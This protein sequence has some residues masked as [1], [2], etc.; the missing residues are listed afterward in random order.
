[1]DVF[2]YRCL[3]F[4]LT[5]NWVPLCCCSRMVILPELSTILQSWPNSLM[6]HHSMMLPLPCF[7]VEMSSR[8][9]ERGWFCRH[10]LMAKVPEFPVPHAMRVF[11]MLS[12]LFSLNI[13]EVLQR[14]GLCVSFSICPIS[15]LTKMAGFF[16]CPFF[17][18]LHLSHIFIRLRLP[19]GTWFIHAVFYLYFFFYLRLQ[20]TGPTT[21]LASFNW[22]Y[23]S[24]CE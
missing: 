10:F 19:L 11:Q 4:D 17:F 7:I 5:F 24:C 2:C 14:T 16:F 9:D 3:A 15:S 21:L 1:M 20:C 23:N 13:A 8:N 12:C 18:F 6:N 22:D